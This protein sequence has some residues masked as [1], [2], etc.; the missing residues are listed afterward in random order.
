MVVPGVAFDPQGGRLG[1]GKGYYDG[2]L[3][4]MRCGTPFVALAFESQDRSGDSYVAARRRHAQDDY[5][6][7]DLRQVVRASGRMS[8]RLCFSITRGGNV[9][10][11]A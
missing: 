1:Y 9:R 2:L 6:T 10:T 7:N 8:S 3:K 11:Q 4:R 5:G